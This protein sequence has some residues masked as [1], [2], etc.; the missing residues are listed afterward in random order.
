M[1]SDVSFVFTLFSFGGNYHK[2]A[3]I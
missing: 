2:L 3:H 1:T